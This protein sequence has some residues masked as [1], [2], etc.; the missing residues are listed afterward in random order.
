MSM[1]EDEDDMLTGN[2][3]FACLRLV[4]SLGYSYESVNYDCN[5]IGEHNSM[6]MHEPCNPTLVP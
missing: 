1:N 4:S 3:L 2:I 6:H 5:G